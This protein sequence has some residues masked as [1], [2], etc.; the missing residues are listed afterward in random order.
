M[1]LAN[2]KS[3]YL[4]KIFL[5]TLLYPQKTTVPQSLLNQAAKEEKVFINN[6]HPVIK[7]NWICPLQINHLI[8]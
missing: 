5:K 6:D 3:C 2:G 1:S 4:N 8:H 7:K